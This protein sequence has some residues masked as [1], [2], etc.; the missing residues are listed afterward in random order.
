MNLK[1]YIRFYFSPTAPPRWEGKLSDLFQIAYNKYGRKDITK[2]SV[3]LRWE[4]PTFDGG[5][6]VKGYQ[7]QV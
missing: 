4:L 2:N 7:L 6:E 1:S 5:S 3:K